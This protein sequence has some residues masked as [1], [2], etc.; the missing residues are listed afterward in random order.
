MRSFS[1]SLALVACASSAT[2]T[3]VTNAAEGDPVV[4]AGAEEL[5]PPDS[6]PEATFARELLEAHNRHRTAHCAPPLRWDERLQRVAQGWA[7]ELV[8]RGCAF[9]HADSPYGENLA[10]GT[11]GS[12]NAEAVVAMWHREVSEYDFARGGFSMQT[13]HFTQVVWRGTERVGCGTATCNGL[14]LFVCN[15]DPPGNVQGQY[16]QNVAPTSCR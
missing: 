11:S 8:R 15:Y 1:L 3:A 5:P 9:E 6:S 14:D 10:A 12:L 7:D 13:G 16:R 4:Q 2:S